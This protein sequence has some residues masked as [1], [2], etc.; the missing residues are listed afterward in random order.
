MSAFDERMAELRAHFLE[1]AAAQRAE[2]EAALAAGEREEI[3]RIAHSLAGS[4]GV[5]GFP[6]VSEDAQAVEEAVDA[7]PGDEELKSIAAQLLKRLR[8]LA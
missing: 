6:R 4:G 2:L 1:R 3:R 5:F 7:G 8:D